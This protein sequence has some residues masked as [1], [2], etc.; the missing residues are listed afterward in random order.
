MAVMLIAEISIEAQRAANNVRMSF[1]FFIFFPPYCTA[2]PETTVYIS[3]PDNLC[4]KTKNYVENRQILIYLYQHTE[5][6]ANI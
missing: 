5:R 4:C 3:F 2:R 6:Y 1:L